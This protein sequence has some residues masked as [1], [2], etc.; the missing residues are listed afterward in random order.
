MCKEDLLDGTWIDMFFDMYNKF[1]KNLCY[2]IN[3]FLDK[4]KVDGLVIYYIFFN[5]WIML[6]L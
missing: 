1:L 6:E 5:V 2:E 4:I 3:F